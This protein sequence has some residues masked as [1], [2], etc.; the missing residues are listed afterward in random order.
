MIVMVHPPILAEQDVQMMIW[1]GEKK[2]NCWGRKEEGKKKVGRRDG[3]LVS[4][5]W[6][7]M[8]NE[9]SRKWV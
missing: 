1:K 9:H 7:A 8:A 6:G 3:L 5:G 2:K 4:R